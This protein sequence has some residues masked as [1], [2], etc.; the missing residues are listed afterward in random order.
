MVGGGMVWKAMHVKQGDLH[1]VMTVFIAGE[2]ARR[3]GRGE[4]RASIVAL[5]RGNARGAKGRRKVDA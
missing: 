4:V 5:K 3:A 1:G 2:A